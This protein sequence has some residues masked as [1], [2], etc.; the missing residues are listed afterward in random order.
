MADSCVYDVDIIIIPI[1]IFGNNIDVDDCA[2]TLSISLFAL[3]FEQCN[4]FNLVKTFA[5]LFKEEN[6][7]SS[8]FQFPWNINF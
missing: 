8:S 6:E 2:I 7:T 5:W 4:V 1:I 3:S